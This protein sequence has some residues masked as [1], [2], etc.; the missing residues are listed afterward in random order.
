M[1]QSAMG[2]GAPQAAWWTCFPA[3]SAEPWVKLCVRRQFKAK[4]SV[5]SA[6]ITTAHK[7]GMH[8]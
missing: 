8:T 5:D 3:V 7:Y 2:N 1:A 4:Q 6:V